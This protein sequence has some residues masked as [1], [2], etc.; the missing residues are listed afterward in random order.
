MRLLLFLMGI[1][2][3]M[4]KWVCHSMRVLVVGGAAALQ[5]RWS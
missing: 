5:V 4:K 2:L 3:I 1:K